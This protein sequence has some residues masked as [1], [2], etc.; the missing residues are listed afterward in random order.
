MRLITATT[1]STLQRLAKRYGQYG[2]DYDKLEEMFNIDNAM[3][4]EAVLAMMR[5]T[6]A[7]EFHQEEYFTVEDIAAM[8]DISVEEAEKMISEHEDELMANGG[9]VS[10]SFTPPDK[11]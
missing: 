7:H 11:M 9:M 8:W 6:L 4:D 10:V 1:K 5:F 3:T 2:F